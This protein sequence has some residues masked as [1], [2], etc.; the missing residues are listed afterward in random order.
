MNN[1]ISNE[2]KKYLLHLARE[3]IKTKSRKIWLSKKEIEDLSKDL[4]SNGGGFVTLH[5][6]G[7]L[8]GCIGY[9]APEFPIYQTVIENA[10]NAAYSDYR[11]NPLSPEEI[12][13]VCI[14]IS[15][16]TPPKKVE[17]ENYKELYNLIVPYKDGVIIKKGMNSATFLPQV[18]EQLP[19]FD[20]FFSNLCMKAM[21]DPQEWK[22]NNLSIETYTAIVFSEKDKL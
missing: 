6:N 19:N 7:K 20:D 9:I 2:S 13:D 17:Y 21:I 10:Y 3:T 5:K 11:F 22:K 18:W 8:R 12:N 14:E 4:K 1:T 16:L 15:I